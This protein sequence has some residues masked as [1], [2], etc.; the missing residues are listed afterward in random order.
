ME[1]QPQDPSMAI[2]V[3]IIDVIDDEDNVINDEDT[4]IDD[5]DT[6]IDPH[7]SAGLRYVDS[8]FLSSTSRWDI[9]RYH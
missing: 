7:K 8:S 6:V 4:V 5:E 2:L 1:Y 9:Y 3:C